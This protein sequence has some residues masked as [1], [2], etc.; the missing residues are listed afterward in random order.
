MS[1]IERYRYATIKKIMKE[2]LLEYLE[3]LKNN[4]D[5][6]NELNCSSYRENIINKMKSKDENILKIYEKVIWSIEIVSQ[7]GQHITMIKEEYLED[8]LKVVMNDINMNHSEFIDVFSEWENRQEG[9]YMALVYAEELL[10]EEEYNNA[11]AEYKKLLKEMAER[12]GISTFELKRKIP[13]FESPLDGVEWLKNQRDKEDIDDCLENP[14]EED[15]ILSTDGEMCGT[16]LK[17]DR[18]GCGCS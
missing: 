4:N 11:L 9:F 18:D 1:I 10:T 16:D 12:E 14:D 3:E 17:V 7:M 15:I 13:P 6:L 8:M 2:S 5:L